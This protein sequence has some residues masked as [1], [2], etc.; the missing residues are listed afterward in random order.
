MAGLGLAVVYG[1]VRNHHGF[2][3]CES[4]KNEGTSFKIYF[5]VITYVPK[6]LSEERGCALMS[7]EKKQYLLSFHHQ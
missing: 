1:I 7:D 2:I 6:E 4:R 3:Q 5:P